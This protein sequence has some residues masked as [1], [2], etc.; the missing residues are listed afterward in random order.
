MFRDHGQSKKYY[1]GVIGWNARM[2]GIQ[3]AVLRVKLKYLAGWNDSRR[4]HAREYNRLLSPSA[5]RSSSPAKRPMQ[6]ISITS[7]PSA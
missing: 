4:E 6:S 5:L 1:H 7:M 2:D 3:G